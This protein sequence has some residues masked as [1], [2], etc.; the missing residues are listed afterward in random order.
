M[1]CHGVVLDAGQLDRLALELDSRS[2]AAGFVD[3]FLQR[4]PGSL[5]CVQRSLVA[6]KSEGAL[7]AILSVAA[8]AAMA[9][10]VQ[11]E[12]DSRA[13]EHSIRAGDLKAARAAA[14]VLEADA[15]DFAVQ[16]AQLF[17]S[18]GLAGVA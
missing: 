6:G 8:S 1:T 13:V 14:G 4:L 17:S 10:A 3:R 2:A 15:A 11:L 18:L 9:G 12:G 16:A 5:A 7:I